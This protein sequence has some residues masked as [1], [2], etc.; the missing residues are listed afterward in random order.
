VEEQFD[1]WLAGLGD[2]DLPAREIRAYW[3]VKD[4]PTPV[5]DA[6]LREAAYLYVGSWSWP[7]E[8]DEPQSGRCPARRVFDWLFWRGT[9]DGYSVPVLDDQLIEELLRCLEPRPTDLPAPAADAFEV[10]D[11]LIGH[12]GCGVLPEDH[13]PDGR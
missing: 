4:D 8:S 2:G 10:R 12:R 13:G 5:L 6:L 11:F 3:N 1:L 7:H 9:A